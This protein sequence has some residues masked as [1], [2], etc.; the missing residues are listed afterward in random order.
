MAKK[1]GFTLE[2]H[3]AAGAEL[4]D[5]NRRLQ[6]LALQF[7]KA[8]PRSGERSRPGYYLS[9]ALEAVGTARTLAEDV[10]FAEYPDAT[11]KVYYG[12]QE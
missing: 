9:K 2:Q 7:G 4:K 1:P 6:A 12:G 10:M 8:Y 11:T 5:I 3:Q